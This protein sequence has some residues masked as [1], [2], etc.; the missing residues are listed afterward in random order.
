MSAGAGYGYLRYRFGQIHTVNL[1]DVIRRHGKSA[2]DNPGKV[3][4][5]LLVGLGRWGRALVESV[6]GKSERLRFV[7]G[8]EP[9]AGAARDFA[10][11]HGF[12]LSTDY[13]E[14]LLDLAI[15]AVVLAKRKL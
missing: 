1:G 11:R 14:A 10:A 5:V 9:E 4:N 8:V 13:A 2:P 12:K 3:M 15:G 7:L 6:Q